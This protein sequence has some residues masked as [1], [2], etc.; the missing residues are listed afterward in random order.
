MSDLDPEHYKFLCAERTKHLRIFTVTTV[1]FVL[2]FGLAI[3]RG[4]S[5]GW[6]WLLGAMGALF[7]SIWSLIDSRHFDLLVRL[8]QLPD[9]VRRSLGR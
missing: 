2:C 1:I 3:Q 6:G 4:P 9:D 8:H 7:G 5:A